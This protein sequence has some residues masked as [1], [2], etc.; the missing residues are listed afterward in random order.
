MLF[1]AQAAAELA[2]LGLKYRELTRTRAEFEY[3]IVLFPG[4]GTTELA[5]K[6]LDGYLKDIGATVHDWGIGKNHGYVPELLQQM[7]QQVRTLSMQRETKLHLVG[8][9]LGG[10][11]AREVARELPDLVG[12]VVTLGT[13][14]VGGPK[15]TAIGVMYAKWGFDLDAMARDVEMREAKSIENE[16]LAIYSKGDNIVSW[17]ACIDERSPRVRHEEVSGSH[18]GLVVSAKAYEKVRMFLSNES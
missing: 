3:P 11:I 1:E 16:I 6:L 12:K 4:F 15:Y 8:W 7:I 10:Y 2:N 13:P 9:S 14:V 5:L 17:Q 18:L